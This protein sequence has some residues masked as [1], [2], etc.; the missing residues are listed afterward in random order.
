LTAKLYDKARPIFED[1]VASAG[2]MDVLNARAELAKIDRAQGDEI[3]AEGELTQLLADKRFTE[4]WTMMRALRV[5]LR[6]AYTIAGKAG[7]AGEANKIEAILKDKHCP[8]CGSDKNVLPIVYGLHSGRSAGVHPG[9]CLV[10]QYSP[11]WWC[12]TDSLE[13]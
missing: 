5:R 13:F 6:E 9:G 12:E 7:E 10:D 11:R 2:P 8:K 4:S 3:K 1:I